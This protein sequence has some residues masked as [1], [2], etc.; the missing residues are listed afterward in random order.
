[1]KR[2]I[3]RQ[4]DA[5]MQTLQWFVVVA[6]ELSQK[7]KL[8]VYPSIYVHTLTYD[9]EVWVVT[10]RTRSQLQA[11]EMSFLCEESRLSL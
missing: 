11:T 4:I 3:D 8:S 10:K 5:A 6:K 1:M 2:D 7:V 9:H